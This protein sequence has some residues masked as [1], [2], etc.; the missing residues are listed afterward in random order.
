[1]DMWWA[2]AG[3]PVAGAVSL[4]IVPWCAPLLDCGPLLL[5]TCG[6]EAV[7]D[8]QQSNLKTYPAQQASHPT[9]LCRKCHS[10]ASSNTANVFMRPL[11]LSCYVTQ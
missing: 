6:Q 8:F 5:C 11:P 9:R 1:M 3:G 10:Q 4:L 2:G 7:Q